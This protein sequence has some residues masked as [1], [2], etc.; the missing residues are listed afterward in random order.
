[1]ERQFYSENTISKHVSEHDSSVM[2]NFN[3]TD[4]TRYIQYTLYNNTE[5]CTMPILG[6]GNEYY[7]GSATLSGN[8]IVICVRSNS[9][10]SLSSPY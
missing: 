7:M 2:S 1:M 10:D 8:N 5:G 9:V 4:G 3:G 6:N